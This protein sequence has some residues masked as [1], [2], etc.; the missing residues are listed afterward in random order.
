MDAL[1]HGHPV[2]STLGHVAA[3]PDDFPLRI[4][5][6]QVET[7]VLVDDRVVL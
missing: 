5:V 2:T 1:D 3:I 4:V 7:P 6:D